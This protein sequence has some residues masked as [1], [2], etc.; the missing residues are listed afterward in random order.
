MTFNQWITVASFA[1]FVFS[2]AV[3]FYIGIFGDE[4]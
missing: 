4:E 2:A 3:I 1:I